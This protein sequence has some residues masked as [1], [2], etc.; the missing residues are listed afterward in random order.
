MAFNVARRASW[1]LVLALTGCAG[2][3]QSPGLRQ[4]PES[5]VAVLEH[6]DPVHGGIVV[7]SI[8]GAWRGIGIKHQYLLTPGTHSV[9][10]ALNKAFLVSGEVTRLL[11]AKPGGRYEIKGL[12]DESAKRW[13]FVII[14]KR[15]GLRVDY[16][17]GC[18]LTMRSAEAGCPGPTTAEPSPPR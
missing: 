3:Y 2:S 9:G 1:P 13:D 18:S 12:V 7:Q 14:D 10:V 6:A 4:V 5:K 17:R 11:E 15:S 16:T 8:D